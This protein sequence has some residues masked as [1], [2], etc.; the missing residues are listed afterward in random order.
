MV[1]KSMLTRCYNPAH[2]KRFPAYNGCTVDKK[3]LLYSAF[4]DWYD[5]THPN[6]GIKYQLDKDILFSGNKI[7]SDITC[8]WVPSAI[9]KLLTYRKNGNLYS[10]ITCYKTTFCIRINDPITNSR[11]RF[12][13]YSLNDALIRYRKEKLKII[14]NVASDS[15]NKNEITSDV[16]NSLCTWKV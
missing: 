16:F 2:T 15:Y 4:K 6:N 3:W 5:R 7:Y 11:L 10:G 14:K 12:T 1:W 9:N 8:C 13:E